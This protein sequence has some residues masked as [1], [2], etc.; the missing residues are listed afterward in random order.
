[1]K[2][3]VLEAFQPTL[4]LS[5]KWDNAQ[6]FITEDFTIEEFKVWVFEKLAS[7]AISKDVIS[8][9]VSELSVKR[10]CSSTALALKRPSTDCV[11]EV[12]KIKIKRC[13]LHY[14]T[15]T[16]TVNAIELPPSNWSPFF[17]AGF[18][19]N[20]GRRGADF[21]VHESHD[22][23]PQTSQERGSQFKRAYWLYVG[24]IVL[25]FAA[26]AGYWRRQ[27]KQGGRLRSRRWLPIDQQPAIL[28]LKLSGKW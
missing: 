13:S 12:I 9:A 27:Q 20:F 7:W 4:S 17:F 1:M 19:V 28:L 2:Y 25:V 16:T 6:I 8:R 21:L 26:A 15:Y 10:S 14:K 23:L 24:V 18:R 3:S 5:T 22:L 11:N